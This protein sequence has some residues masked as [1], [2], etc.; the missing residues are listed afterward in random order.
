[1]SRAVFFIVAIG[2]LISAIISWIEP[3]P[4]PA[5]VSQDAFGWY[6]F[7]GGLIVFGLGL[8]T[9]RQRFYP[10]RWPERW[11]SRWIG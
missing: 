7:V 11:P 9:P 6:M 8:L 1:M 4:Y 2:F 3:Q 5:L 10:D